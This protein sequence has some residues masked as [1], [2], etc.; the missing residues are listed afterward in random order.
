MKA[1]QLRHRVTIQAQTTAQDEY[2]QPV[3]TWSDVATVHAAVED[4][5][6]REFFAAQQVPTET[7]TTRI[8]I[9]WRPDVSASMRVVGAGRT[10]DVRAVLD[11]DGRRRQLQLMCV[12]VVV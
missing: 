7:I 1:G 12:E 5:S 2:G 4:L 6:G 11:P 3:Q 10:W 9:R 8:T